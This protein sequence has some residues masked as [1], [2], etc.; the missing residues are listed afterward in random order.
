MEAQ[1]TQESSE[2]ADA[3]VDGAAT[4]TG[5]TNKKRRRPGKSDPNRRRSRATED[6]GGQ[7]PA[8]PHT[9]STNS[10]LTT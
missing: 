5:P 9:V 1:Q 8:A 10:R 2:S 4:P 7:S 6:W 3:P